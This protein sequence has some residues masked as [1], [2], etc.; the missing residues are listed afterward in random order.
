MTDSYRAVVPEDY[1]FVEAQVPVFLPGADGTREMVGD[2]VVSKDGEIL[3]TMK[4]TDGAKRVVDML[5]EGCLRGVS[6]DL[7]AA[8]P[9]C[10]FDQGTFVFEPPYLIG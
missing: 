3:I 8:Q 6:F 4:T 10:N 1:E 9:A 7:R 2:A 5:S